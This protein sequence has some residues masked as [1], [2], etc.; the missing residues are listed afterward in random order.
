MGDAKS[1][2]LPLAAHFKLSHAQCSTTTQENALMSKLLYD[3]IVGNLMYLM[4]Y[5][6]P[7]ISLAMG[8][9]SRYMSNPGKVHWEAV[10]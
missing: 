3:K 6:R 9:V 8:K 4:V 5:T 10:K 7:K 1:V 2:S